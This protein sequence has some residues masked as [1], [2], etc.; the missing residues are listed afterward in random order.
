MFDWSLLLPTIIGFVSLC[1]IS[2][3]NYILNDI[4]DL[5]KDRQN[6]EKRTRPLAS[7]SIAVWQAVIMFALFAAGSV[8]LALSPPKLFLYSVIAL[9]LLTQLYSVWLKKEFFADVLIIGINFV[10]RAASGTFIINVAISP[11]LI[12]GVFFL[13]IFLAV[14]KRHAELAVLGDKAASHRATLKQYTRE[15]TGALMIITTSL[16]IMAYSLYSF[17]SEHRNLFLTLPFALYAI[18]RYFNLVYSGN[19]VARH[20]ERVFGDLRMVIAMLLWAL[21]TGYLIYF[22]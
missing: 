9:F 21:L 15:I 7:G 19:A 20:P 6:P 16:L 14:G 12:V 4:I 18:F 13:A 8:Y 3:S 10:I 5:K 1:L 2:S 22:V 11:W 17:F